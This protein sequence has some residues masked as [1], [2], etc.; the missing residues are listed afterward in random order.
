MVALSSL[1]KD[2]S[3]QGRRQRSIGGCSHRLRLNL[4]K[5]EQ[6]LFAI[7]D[8]EIDFG[9]QWILDDNG[10]DGFLKW[11]FSLATINGFIFEGKLKRSCAA[12]V[13]ALQV[14]SAWTVTLASLRSMRL[15]VCFIS[16]SSLR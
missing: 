3:C 6:L 12:S 10:G 7:D 14:L 5:D 8:G 2:S 13:A 16:P 11:S 9:D 1:V 4:S 15:T